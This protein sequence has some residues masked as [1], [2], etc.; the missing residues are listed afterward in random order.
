MSLYV[1]LKN[2]LRLF[3]MKTI[4]LTVS[5]GSSMISKYLMKFVSSK[6]RCWKIRC[7]NKGQPTCCSRQ[8]FLLKLSRK[9]QKTQLITSYITE[10][11]FLL[12]AKKKKGFL[13]WQSW[14]FEMQESALLY[15]Q[16]KQTQMI[17]NFRRWLN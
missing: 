13:L 6:F 4:D 17:K 14:H 1:G 2:I 12:I 5:L 9:E 3:I 10:L 8:I 7:P 16:F 15:C 11:N